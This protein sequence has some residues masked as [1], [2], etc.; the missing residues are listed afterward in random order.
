VG[1]AVLPGRDWVYP[2]VIKHEYLGTRDRASDGGRLARD[3]F[4]LGIANT[5]TFGPPV[6]PVKT[7]VP[8]LSDMTTRGSKFASS[9]P[10]R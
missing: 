5:H 4:R 7:H 10:V 6:H 3:Q 2:L 9:A 1:D 8:K